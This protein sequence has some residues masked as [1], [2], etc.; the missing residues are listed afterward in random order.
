MMSNDGIIFDKQQKSRYIIVNITWNSDNWRSIDINEKAGSRYAQKNPG[1]ESFNFEF[2]KKGLDD[3]NYVFGYAQRR[4]HPR[5]FE[6]PGIIFF[7]TKDLNDNKNKI[8]GV[9][10][11][12]EVLNPVLET[13]LQ[14]FENNTLSSNIK[15]VKEK[16]ML[17]PIQLDASQY[18]K[19]RLVP[20]SGL[21]YITQD[22]ASTIITDEVDTARENNIEKNELDKLYSI[23]ELITGKKYVD[24]IVE[25]V[26]DG[27]EQLVFEG[28]EKNKSK[29]E[30]IK[31]LKNL[32]PQTPE[33]IEIKGKTYKR[34]N[35]IIAQLKNIRNYKCQICGIIIQKKNKDF[36]IEAAHIKMKSKKGP[37]T[38][39]NILILCPNHHKEFDYGDREIIEHTKRSIIFKMNGKKFEIDLE[40]K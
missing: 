9:Y 23:F 12:A 17:F 35:K 25:R 28:I 5:R 10:G 40:L 32:G 30:I 16:S 22:L 24:I 38:P 4:G 20:Q 2:N 26:N 34:D 37:E 3:E 15:A 31:E 21:R 36:Y 7:F 33:L 27:Q 1:H 6:E 39:D 14:I 18:S 13:K 11:N 29:D 8:V 19:K